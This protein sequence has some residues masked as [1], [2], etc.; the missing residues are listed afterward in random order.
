MSFWRW[1]S[2][3]LCRALC[4][5]R[6]QGTAVRTAAYILIGCAGL[7]H[8]EVGISPRISGHPDARRKCAFTTPRYWS[9]DGCPSSLAVRQTCVP[10]SRLLILCIPTHDLLLD[11]EGVRRRMCKK[12]LVCCF[13]EEPH[14]V[15]AAV[16]AR[17]RPTPPFP[18]S[19]VPQ[20]ARLHLH[21]KKRANQPAPFVVRADF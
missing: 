7:W 11:I 19:R 17:P 10:F 16:I 2:L 15:L 4:D 8:F 14:L 13:I 9:G 18:S 20:R 1:G 6:M 12:T 21:E 3:S 5:N